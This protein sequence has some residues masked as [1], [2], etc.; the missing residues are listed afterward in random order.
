MI[1]KKI[2]ED[3]E[4]F[5]IFCE[6]HPHEAYDLNKRGFCNYYRKTLGTKTTNKEIKSL[7]DKTR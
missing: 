6:L 4:I 7:I 2:T 5:E 1:S 3:R